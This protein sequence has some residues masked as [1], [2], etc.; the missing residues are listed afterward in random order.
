MNLTK[1]RLETEAAL[2]IKG[3]K[4]SVFYMLFSCLLQCLDSRDVCEF[5]SAGYLFNRVLVKTTES[6]EISKECQ[7]LMMKTRIKQ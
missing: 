6:G 3:E 2:K 7:K 1:I 5:G 4:V